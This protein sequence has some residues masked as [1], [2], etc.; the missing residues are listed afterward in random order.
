MKT[1]YLHIGTEKTGSTALQAVSA[2]NRDVLMRHGIFYPKTPGE[3]NHIK[4]AMFATA[5]NSIDLRRR[6]NLSSNEAYQAFQARFGEE[7]RCEIEANPCA[8]VILSNEHLSSRLRNAEE[9]RRLAAIIRP[10]ADCVK[11][12]VYL[13]PQTELF[14]SSYSTSIK[15]GRTIALE[16]P[17]HRDDPRYNYELTLSLW[18]KI[19]GDENIIVRVYDRRSLVGNDVVKDFFSITDYAPGPD[20]KIPTSLNGRLGH[21]AACF[22]LQ[23]NKHVPRFVEQGINPDRGDI[24]KLLE[25]HAG[26]T[27]LP[28][29]A[30]V[31]RDI[32]GLYEDSNARVARRFLG[33][34]DG[35]LFSDPSYLDKTA[36]EPLTVDQAVEICAYLW[37]SKQRQLNEAR[38]Q[39]ARLKDRLKSRQ[40]LR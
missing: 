37:R 39:I 14:L 25:A 30:A 23:F 38:S 9:V 21:S 34:S 16:P 5:A 7:L 4:L 18:A 20:I 15:S 36:G 31:L 24:A 28:V 2:V 32:G 35:N 8:R 29:P 13:R 12:V 27:A 1:L 6:S 3:R 26:A 19:F 22:L 11:I 10:L 17:K 40:V 33:R